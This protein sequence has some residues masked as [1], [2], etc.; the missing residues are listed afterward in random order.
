MGDDE[1]FENGNLV[2]DAQKNILERV[3]NLSS[4]T[5]VPG[6]EDIPS[7]RFNFGLPNPGEA[8]KGVAPPPGFSNLQN[9]SS[10]NPAESGGFQLGGWQQTN[11]ST[12]G[13]LN[14]G[15]QRSTGGLQLGSLSTVSNSQQGQGLSLSSLATSHLS[16]LPTSSSLGGL[17]IGSLSSSSGVGGLQVGSL[18]SST[19]S[20]GPSLKSL[21]SS[22]LSSVSENTQQSSNLLLNSQPSLPS[23]NDE[24][25]PTLG[26]L[27]SNHLKEIKMTGGTSSDFKIS[28][29]KL[30][31]ESSDTNPSLRNLAN[32][33]KS[34]T[35]SSNFK[36]P[37]LSTELNGME[38]PSLSGRAISPDHQ[39]IDL[40]SALKIESNANDDPMLE[41]I[42]IPKPDPP[43]AID[44]N[45]FVSSTTFAKVRSI[46]SKK[47]KSSFGVTLTRRWSRKVPRT[48]IGL[49]YSFQN[50]D[51]FKFDK[52][53]PDDVVLEAQKQSRA[54]NRLN[55]S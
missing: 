45:I 6:Q 28:L 47:T 19:Q 52:P 42:K 8:K 44:L 24:N 27:A 37:C 31:N 54:F 12:P 50:V 1:N 55:I 36:I 41:N 3:R 7:A 46:L 23:K 39:E 33:L 15:L 11:L 16:S 49:K 53:S 48:K 34:E 9:K 35:P 4:E 14:L 18:S 40:L 29:N 13:A 25:R 17:Q 30:N 38:I 32:N 20:S 5:V 2:P 22:H 51:P 10:L 43:K 21:A 26:S